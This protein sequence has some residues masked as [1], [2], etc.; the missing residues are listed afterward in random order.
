[1]VDFRKSPKT[2]SDGLSRVA[3]EKTTVS[4]KTLY[5]HDWTDPTTWYEQSVRVVDEVATNS[6]DNQSYQ[7]AHNNVI[8]NY[9]GKISEEDNLF[10]SDGHSY[11]VSVSVNDQDGYVEQDPHYASGGDYTINYSDGYV[12]FTYAL[13]SSDTVKVTYHYE[14]GSRFTIAP[15]S[16]K[17]LKIMLAEVQFSTDVIMTD[18]VHFDTYAYAA[19][20]APQLGL[21]PGTKIKIQGIIYKGMKDFYNDAVRA[22]PK[23]AAIGGTGYRSAN[24]DMVVL[25]WDYVAAASLH[26]SYGMETRVFL[27]HDTPLDGSFGTATFYCTSEDESA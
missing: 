26:S 22:Y 1:M 14:N 6:G 27:E 18:S 5:T 21:P 10:D 4:R 12:D 17:E 15:T 13:D 16:G 25:D 3:M 9:H 11:R 19:V 2:T 20:F 23:M 7:L 24:F 8:D